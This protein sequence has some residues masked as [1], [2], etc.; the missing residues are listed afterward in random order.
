MSTGNFPF[1]PVSFKNPKLL[2]YI[3]MEMRPFN[4]SSG[5]DF[6]YP[7]TPN[8]GVSSIHERV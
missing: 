8:W 1:L 7:S 5:G 4:L 3:D 2:L 6:Y